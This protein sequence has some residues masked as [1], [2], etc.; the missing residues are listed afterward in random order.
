MWQVDHL[1]EK[2]ISWHQERW[3]ESNEKNYWKNQESLT[4]D[5]D[6][7][8]VH[9]FKHIHF[10]LHCNQAAVYTMVMRKYDS[11]S[12]YD[13]RKELTDEDV[14]ASLEGACI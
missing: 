3:T 12:P 4:V 13:E 14:C 5:L 1:I 11:N 10:F 8:V 6:P 2:R 7:E 9:F